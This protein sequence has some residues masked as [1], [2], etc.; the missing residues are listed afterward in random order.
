MGSDFIAESKAT[1]QLLRFSSDKSK[2]SDKTAP[3]RSNYVK[4]IDARYGQSVQE[5]V[6][7]TSLNLVLTSPDQRKKTTT[8]CMVHFPGPPAQVWCGMGDG[9]V[10]IYRMPSLQFLQSLP[11]GC[12]R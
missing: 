10:K 7:P 2:S 9:Q 4:Q 1:Q 12:S 11:V 5:Q 3:V 8:E 6:F